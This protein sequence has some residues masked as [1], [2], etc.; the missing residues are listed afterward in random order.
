L[1]E[2]IND[3]AGNNAYQSHSLFCQ[4]KKHSQSHFPS[5]WTVIFHIVIPL[6]FYEVKC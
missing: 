3:Y 2:E 4:A 5:I 1:A 6:A